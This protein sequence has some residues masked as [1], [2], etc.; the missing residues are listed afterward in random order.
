MQ[1]PE[2]LNNIEKPHN[3]Q[4]CRR[5]QN[6]QSCRRMQK[7]ARAR[8]HFCVKKLSSIPVLSAESIGE[9]EEDFDTIQ[10]SRKSSEV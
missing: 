2:R 4:S 1:R 10:K 3:Y 6:Y 8:V 7:C 9:A 5:M